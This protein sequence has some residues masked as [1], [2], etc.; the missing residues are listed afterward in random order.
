MLYIGGAIS[1]LDST[2]TTVFRSLITKI[3]QP[4]EVGRVFSVVAIFQAILPF[5]GS[6]LFGLLYK[7]TVATHPNAFIFLIAI[8]KGLVF[9]VVLTVYMGMKKG[10][11]RQSITEKYSMA[12]V[13]NS[14]IC[15]NEPEKEQ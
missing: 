2:S 5:I 13:E 1:F 11:S 10:I 7:N 4:D 6:P 3:V 12:D 9:A 14:I 8:T 15:E